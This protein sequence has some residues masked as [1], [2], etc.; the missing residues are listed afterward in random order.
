MQT[1]AV[2]VPHTPFAFAAVRLDA[3]GTLPASSTSQFLEGEVR[4][5]LG[6][7]RGCLTDFLGAS[8]GSSGVRFLS[9]S[10]PLWSVHPS[11]VLR[12]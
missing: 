1:S 8:D 3:Q 2:E 7:Y 10:P 5:A 9:F 12:L 11:L 4:I 6:Y